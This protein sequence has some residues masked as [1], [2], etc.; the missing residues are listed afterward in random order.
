MHT[1]NPKH[2]V[3]RAKPAIAR[4]LSEFKILFLRIEGN[5]LRIPKFHGMTKIVPFIKEYGCAINVFGGP[6]ES[7]HKHFLKGPGANTQRRYNKFVMQSTEHVYE[8]LTLEV[9][10]E[11]DKRCEER[12]V[13]VPTYLTEHDSRH[14]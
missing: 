3:D 9:S 12:G 4:V 10:Y 6:A 5:R 14:V 8:S 7:H 13:Q 11:A 2:D 1:A